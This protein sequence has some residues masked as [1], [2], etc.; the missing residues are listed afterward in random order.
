MYIVVTSGVNMSKEVAHNFWKKQNNYPEFGN[1]KKRRLYEINYIVPK[2]VGRS[3]LDIGCGTGDLL[4]CLINLVEIDKVYGFDLSENLLK[5][6]HPSIEK[7]I[8]DFYSYNPDELPLVD[9]TILSGSL[10]YVFDDDVVMQLLSNINTD[11][12]FIRSSC[13]MEKNRQI[14]NNFSKVLKSDYSS[15][16]RTV[17]EIITL[18][19]NDYKIEFIDRIYPDEIESKF[20]TKQFYFVARKK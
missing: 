13:S 10:Q 12:I 7:K 19:Q 1:I 3:I 2:I 8:F 14:V 5:N 4:N 9:N 11:K 6:L 15:V 16:Y 20:D 17:P 18:L